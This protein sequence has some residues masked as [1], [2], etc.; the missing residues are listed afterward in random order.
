M[1]HHEKTNIFFFA[2]STGISDMTQRINLSLSLSYLYGTF[3]I[4]I[5]FEFPVN[6]VAFFLKDIA[7]ISCSSLNTEYLLV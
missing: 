1:Q 3:Y 6:T 4:E 7:K 5:R 2:P